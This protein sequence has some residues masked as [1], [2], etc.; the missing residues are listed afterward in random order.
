M[1]EII[2]EREWREFESNRWHEAV[3]HRGLQLRS[4]DPEERQLVLQAIN[5]DLERRRQLSWKP[6]PA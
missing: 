6:K 3:R 4:L 2:S 1:N 5:D